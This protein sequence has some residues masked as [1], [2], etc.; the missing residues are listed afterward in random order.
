MCVSAVDYP[1]FITTNNNS[2]DGLIFFR[3]IIIVR[4]FIK[5]VTSTWVNIRKDDY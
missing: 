4:R 1:Y 3:R 2:V 5:I